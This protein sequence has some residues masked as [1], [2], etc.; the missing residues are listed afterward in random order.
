MHIEKTN[1]KEAFDFLIEQAYKR[2]KQSKN[3]NI[4]EEFKKLYLDDINVD[5]KIYAAFDDSKVIG[6]AYL[7]YDNYIKDI[8]VLD[9]YKHLNIEEQLINEIIKDNNKTIVA[10]INPSDITANYKGDSDNKDDLS[11]SNYYYK[12]KS[13]ICQ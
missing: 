4:Y 13:A 8:Y 3:K 5:D 1:N 10:S 9:E 12:G 6:C 11:D 2:I 7:T